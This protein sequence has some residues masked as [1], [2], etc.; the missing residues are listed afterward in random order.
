MASAF[1]LGIHLLISGTSLRDRLV[2][3]LGT[4][5]YLG[6]FSLASLGGLSWMVLA[7]NRVSEDAV[8]WSAP[9][10]F[11]HSGPIFMALAFIF[12][13]TGLSTPNP[14]AVEMQGLLEKEGAVRAIITVTRHPV[15]WAI[16]LW[17]FFHLV[18][19][20]Q[21]STTV[22]FGTFLVLS[23]LGTIFIDRKRAR[24]SG[25]TWV[26]F[27][28]KTSNVP[29][30]AIAQGRTKVDFKGMGWIRIVSGFVLYAVFVF[31]HANWFGVLPMP[32]YV[33]G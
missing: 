30:V 24:R 14:T 5:V 25:E 29:F 2:A 16:I 7:Y 12:A 1:F 31:F 19:N 20:G 15:Q 23:S 13:V 26:P 32:G 18:A 17:A 21:A 10:L 9:T 33:V 3:S 4:R 28:E 22:F 8:L 27:A 11:A 6:L